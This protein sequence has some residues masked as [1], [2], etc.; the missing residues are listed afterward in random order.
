M[1]TGPLL[2]TDLPQFLQE[3]GYLRYLPTTNDA[4]KTIWQLFGVSS[5]GKVRAVWVTSR[6][7][8]TFKSSDALLAF[9]CRI[10]RGETSLLISTTDIVE[11]KNLTPT[12]D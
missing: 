8:R 7:Q 12:K 1:I 9:H 3:G 5:D 2:T 4:G 10:Y 11:T 6:S